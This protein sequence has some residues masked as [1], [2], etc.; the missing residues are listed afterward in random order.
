MFYYSDQQID[1]W[2][3]DDTALGDLTTRNMGINGQ[4]G[5]ITYAY[6]QDTRASGVEVAARILQKTGLDVTRYEQDGTDVP[7]GALLVSAEGP[8]E[9]L[10]MA[11]KVTQNIM[12][13]A[14]GVASYMA[15]MLEAGRRVNPLLH[16]ACTRKCIPGT[17]VLSNAA[18]VHGGGIIH[19]G[20]TAETIL[21]FAHHRLFSDNPKDFAGHIARLRAAAP[22]KKIVVEVENMD[23]AK[24]AISG[25]PD[26]LQLD[27]FLLQDIESVVQMAAESSPGCLV[28]VA[29]GVN[30][31]N[32]DVFAKTG[33]PLIVTSSPYYAGPRDVKVLM[34]KI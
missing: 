22:E 17:K 2:L 20:G 5:R 30:R 13:W 14:G 12:E 11:W 21:L 28:S 24:D 15:A 27:K 26:V 32:I 9:K 16:I 7:A 19:R 31:D 18:V 34:E 6:K 3:L 1:Q 29:G 33:A 23:E 25:N 10:H 4:M 8:A